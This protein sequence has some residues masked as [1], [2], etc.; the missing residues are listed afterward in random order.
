MPAYEVFKPLG[1]GGIGRLALCKRRIFDGVVIDYGGLNEVVLY[2]RFEKRNQNVALGGAFALFDLHAELLCA[3]ARCGV[4][5]PLVV[6]G[7]AVLLYGLLHGV[8]RPGCAHIYLCALV[9]YLRRAAHVLR[10]GAVH[11]FDEVHHA[12]VVGI[13]LIHL[14][15]GEFGVV[16]GVHA[17]VAED[18]ADLVHALQPADYQPLQIELGLYAKVHV[19]IQRVVM[20]LEGARRRAYLE[21]GEY[22]RI[23]LQIAEVIEILPYLAYYL[24]TLDKCRAHLGVYYEIEVA[25]AVFEVDIRK[26]VLLFGQGTEGLGEH[27]YM[28]AVHGD[29]AR[30]RLEHKAP[31]ADDIAYVVVLFIR[32]IILFADVVALYVYL[33]EPVSVGDMRKG[34]LA[35]DAARHQSSRNGDLFA[36]ERLEIVLYRRGICGEL[37]LHL[38]IGVFALGNELRQ[39]FPSYFCLFGKAFLFL[40]FGEGCVVL[41]VHMSSDLSALL[42]RFKMLWAVY[43]CSPH[44]PPG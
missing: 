43:K 28:R 27:L 41:F 37:V 35:H 10:Y 24:R 39:L 31:Y 22:G 12:L 25:L 21:R 34:G 2:K 23:N 44:N 14:H 42:P 38:F 36:L 19:D 29:L 4:V 20:R 33:N 11:I 30:L 16:E 18:T 13:G 3:L 1:K 7:A 5:R 6:V 17:L 32:H 8:A 9:G 26:A 40:L 15:R